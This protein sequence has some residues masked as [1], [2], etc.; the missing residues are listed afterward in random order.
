MPKELSLI[1]NPERVAA[2]NEILQAHTSDPEFDR[3][4]R[5]ASSLL[6]VPTCLISLVTADRQEFKGAFGLPEEMEET[7]SIPLTHSVCK[8]AVATDKILII[9]DATV[10]PQFSDNP[11]I[12]GIGLK[13]YLGF[14]LINSGGQ[15]LGAF[16]LI[17]YVPRR[18]T[19]EEIDAVRDFAGLAVDLI[20][21]AAMQSRTAAAF[22]IILHDLKSPLSGILMASALFKEQI[23]RVP[24]QLHVLVNTLSSSTEAAVK[25]VEGLSEKDRDLDKTF[26]KDPGALLSKVIERQTLLADAKKITIE[27]E[28]CMLPPLAV[29]AW[30][31][32]QLLENLIG[33]A[34]KYTPTGS[35]VWISSGKNGNEGWFKIRDEGPGFSND[36]I[37][38][39]YQRY[40][41]L[42]AKPTGDE[43]STGIG[44]SIVKRLAEQNGGKVKLLSQPGC[45]A[46]FQVSFSLW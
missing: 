26:S 20:E 36:D 11:L 3:L 13:A 4:T 19:D 43:D 28:I 10:D 5:L 30:A 39:M 40:R 42:S 7:R 37:P 34:V 23:H 29:P 32:E 21:S 22:D 46:E 17:D 6:K 45:G 15:V 38:R 18:W 31:L 1:T 35:S 41:R 25:L 16:C 9:E 27:A 44:L 24:D 8:T 33:N 12:E 2:V 14:P